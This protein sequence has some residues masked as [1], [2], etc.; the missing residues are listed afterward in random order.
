MPGRSVG[1]LPDGPAP[2]DGERFEDVARLGSV[3]IEA[4]VS[5]ATPEPTVYVQDHDEWVL[6]LE[7]RATL[8][9]DGARVDLEAGSWVL[10][11]ARTRH[12]V[13]QT[14]AGT[15]WLALHAASSEG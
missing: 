8:D 7:G 5:S 6:V 14:D 12:R 15:R 4:I 9:V 1:R 3:R 11:P 10:L 13:L 2:S